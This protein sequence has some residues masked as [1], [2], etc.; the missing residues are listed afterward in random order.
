MWSRRAV[1]AGLGMA[2]TA[3]PS[4]LYGADPVRDI[5]TRGPANADTGIRLDAVELALIGAMSEGIIPATDTPGALG[6]GVPDFFSML[7]SEWFLPDEQIAFRVG[8]KTYDAASQARF[9]RPFSNCSQEQQIAL[10]TQWDQEADGARSAGQP[11]YPPFAQFKALT[12][13]GYYT[14]EIGQNQELHTILDA[15]ERDPNGPVM[16]PVP[17]RL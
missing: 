16:M 2:A 3:L 14:S 17:V 10:L 7:F 8:L 1:M 9:G 11:P 4:Y 5:L 15:G 13:V 6:A 12:V